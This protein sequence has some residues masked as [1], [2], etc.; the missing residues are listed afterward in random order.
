MSRIPR[1]AKR[2]AGEKA[3]CAALEAAGCA[4]LPISRVGCPDLVVFRPAGAG[5]VREAILVEVKSPTGKPTPAQT[6]WRITWTG[7][8][9]VTVR[10]VDEAL[11]LLRSR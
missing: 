8:A 7:P 2:D 9:P 11:A 6:W 4:V 3:I 1:Q 10:S 5:R